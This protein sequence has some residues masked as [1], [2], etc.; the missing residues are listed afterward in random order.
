MDSMVEIFLERANNE[1]LTAKSLIK[2]S[3]IVKFKKEF[4]L[5]KNITFYSSV[6]SHSYYSIFYAAKAIL[7]TKNIKTSFPEVHKKT[8]EL[9][10]NELIKTGILD[11]NLL[12]IYKTMLIRA[13]V[14]LEIFK[15]EKYKRGKFT[16]K[17][18]P[19]ANKLPAN[20]SLKNAKLFVSNIAKI[21]RNIK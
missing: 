14:L 9:F 3:E 10:E 20:N 11:V 12:K 6:I 13:D 16:Y 2:L 4:E 21:I 15:E 7:L 18:L 1:L 19:Q 8:L 17:T 5:P